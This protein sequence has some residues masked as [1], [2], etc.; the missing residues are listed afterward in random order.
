MLPRDDPYEL[1]QSLMDMYTDRQ[2]VE[3][4]VRSAETQVIIHQPVYFYTFYHH[5]GMSNRQ[6]QS[7]C[8]RWFVS[9]SK[10][11]IKISIVS[12]MKITG[13]TIA[14][15]CDSNSSKV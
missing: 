9:I 6:K 8:V 3:S 5:P 1:K 2:W 7:K 13:E 10:S 15:A 4:A 14:T 12:T 11:L